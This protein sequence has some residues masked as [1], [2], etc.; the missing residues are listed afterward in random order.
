MSQKLFAETADFEQPRRARANYF[1]VTPAALLAVYY[2]YVL[3]NGWD[4]AVVELRPTRC[5]LVKHFDSSYFKYRNEGI[6]ELR[7][8][9][10]SLGADTLYAPFPRDT[11]YGLQT[12][13]EQQVLVPAWAYRCDS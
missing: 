3:F 6:L 4:V 2:L 11:H 8:Q 12:A 7:S 9:A 10:A 5:E 1:W 13:G